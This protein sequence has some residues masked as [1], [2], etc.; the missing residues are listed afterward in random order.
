MHKGV[1]IKGIFFNGT[2]NNLK[3]AEFIRVYN[4]TPQAVKTG[5]SAE[6]V[7]LVFKGKKTE[8]DVNS[9]EVEK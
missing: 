1:R 7:W 2:L 5:V 3:K 4:E 8:E 9:P 6:D